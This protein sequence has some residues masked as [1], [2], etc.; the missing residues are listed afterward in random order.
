MKINY[1][2][3]TKRYKSG[4]RNHN[5]TTKT[6]GQIKKLTCVNIQYQ[7]YKSVLSI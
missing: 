5:Q 2:H 7:H 6:N 4:K 3:R 1:F